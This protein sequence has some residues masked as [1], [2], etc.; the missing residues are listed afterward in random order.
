MIKEYAMIYEN[1]CNKN[2]IS[3]YKEE[4]PRSDN[5]ISIDESK[6]LAWLPKVISNIQLRFSRVNPLKLN[7]DLVT[8]NFISLTDSSLEPCLTIINVDPERDTSKYLVTSKTIQLSVFD[9]HNDGIISSCNCYNTIKEILYG[10]DERLNKDYKKSEIYKIIR[11]EYQH[12]LDSQYSGCNKPPKRDEP[13]L[14][15]DYLG[16]SEEFKAY[17]TEF[18]TFLDGQYFDSFSDLI[19]KIKEIQKQNPY[20][21][22]VAY[23][24][25]NYDKFLSALEEWW[26]LREND[27]LKME[28]HV[29]PSRRRKL[30]S[31]L[32]G[33][34]VFKK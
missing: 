12:Y 3:V 13:V 16:S 9:M 31:E 30:L 6:F 19:L 7:R 10:I 5:P 34:F 11:H 32:T 26:A 33:R 20:S 22:P 28:Y 8:E 15:S 29:L 17:F 1:L 18:L 27:R 24:F 2:L 4:A 23:L 21:I 14:I 25:K